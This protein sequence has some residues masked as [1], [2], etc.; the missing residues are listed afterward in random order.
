MEQYYETVGG[1]VVVDSAFQ[2]KDAPFLEKSSQTAPPGSAY[3]YLVHEDATSVRQL[4]EW[5][6]RMFQAQCPR[7][8]DKMTYKEYGK[9]RVILNL[10]VLLYNFS[11][12]RIGHNTILNTY[13][14]DKN[15]YY[16]NYQ[17]VPTKQA[18]LS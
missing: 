9:R 6:M 14:H 17:Y 12:S 16:G 5:G 11:C 13:M 4:A 15:N 18:N 1:R 2:L 7:M 10:M 3:E 8:K